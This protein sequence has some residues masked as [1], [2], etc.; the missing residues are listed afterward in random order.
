MVKAI[1]DFGLLTY[2]VKSV[3][4]REYLPSLLKLARLLSMTNIARS[5]SNM[6]EVQIVKMIRDYIEGLMAK[7]LYESYSQ[8]VLEYKLSTQ[9]YDVFGESIYCRRTRIQS[10]EKSLAIP[11][12]SLD[13][14]YLLRLRVFLPVV[15]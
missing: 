9:I 2:V 3:R 14:Q 4:I 5:A 13:I 7:G 11:E 15:W 12:K 8:K 10:Q 1:N 6:V